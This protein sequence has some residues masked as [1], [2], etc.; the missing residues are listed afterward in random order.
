MKN[1]DESEIIV[2]GGTGFIGK[3]LIKRLNLN[4]EKY[5]SFGSKQL[6]LLCKKDTNNVLS[7]INF[8]NKTIILLSA[9][10]P[11]NGEML[12][13][14]IKNLIMLQNLINN[15]KSNEIKQFIYVSS[16]A[17]FPNRLNI[18]ENFLKSSSSLYGLMH[19][20]RENY[21][22]NFFPKNKLTILRPCAVFGPGE[23]SFSYG[24]NKFINEAVKSKSIYLVGNGEEIR[25]HIFIEDLVSAMYIS[26]K[27]NI[28]GNYNLASGKAMSFKK[29]A[30]IIKNQFH[31]NIHIIKQ[32]RLQPIS[33]KTFNI[34][35]FKKTFAQ[36]NICS[37]ENGIKHSL[38][39]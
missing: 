30:L 12:D 32:P 34:K 35:K 24:I 36:I 2:F 1:N 21:L 27:N 29:I 8:K 20:S 26:F 17:I 23:K 14:T 15:I 6:N 33:H 3:S 11:N 39:M 16:D 22:L 5:V 9:L 37:I 4:D 31:D 25:D 28:T 18:T 38:D 19:N 7:K 10:R 13:L